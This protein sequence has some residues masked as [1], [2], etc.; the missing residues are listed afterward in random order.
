MFFAHAA[1]SSIGP[2]ALA[3]DCSQSRQVRP[4]ALSCEKRL[5][6]RW[7]QWSG[8]SLFASHFVYCPD[9]IAMYCP[10]ELDLTNAWLFVSQAPCGL[11]VPVKNGAW[12]GVICS[13]LV[14]SP[15]TRNTC[16]KC[17]TLAAAGGG[18][19]KPP[20]AITVST[21]AAKPETRTIQ[22]PSSTV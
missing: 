12:D 15:M 16:P 22:S 21:R 17:G 14:F 20:R 2:Q 13:T 19:E 3:I 5:P 8:R 9:S 10:S 1:P 4:E 7:W 18:T 6:I 11:T